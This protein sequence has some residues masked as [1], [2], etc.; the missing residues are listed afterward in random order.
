[1][2]ID[3]C[4]KGLRLSINAFKGLFRAFDLL[5]KMGQRHVT[6]KFVAVFRDGRYVCR[7]HSIV[8]HRLPESR[9]MNE[10]IDLFDKTVGPDFPYQFPLLYSCAMLFEQRHQDI[11]SF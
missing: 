4:V 9:Y 5:W 10:Q 6:D 2:F 7:I 1:M 3:R 11:E 8:A